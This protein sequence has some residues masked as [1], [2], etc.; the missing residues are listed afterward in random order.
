MPEVRRGSSL[1]LS[2]DRLPSN[3]SPIVS[4][5]PPPPS[6]S[7]APKPDD[8]SPH[9][10]SFFEKR[11]QSASALSQLPAIQ[12]NRAQSLDWGTRPTILETNSD[13]NTSKFGSKTIYANG[14]DN[15]RRSISYA[16]RETASAY[17]DS[18]A[19]THKEW[20]RR[21]K[22]LQEYYDENPQLLPQLPFTWHHG[23]KRWRLFFFVFLAFVDASVVPI[24]L[25]YGMTYGG[26]TPGWIVFAIITSIWGGP[27]Y[28]EAGMRTLRLIK[29]ERFFRPLGTDSRWSFDILTWILALAI[30]VVTVLFIVG[31]A[32]HI[33]FLRVLSMP[34]PA[35]LYCLGGSV[36][37]LTLYHKMGWKAPFRISS[38]A[39]GEK[40]C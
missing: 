10:S 38:T 8:G 5:T 25:Y 6:K 24:A 39:K 30:G 7:K 14:A 32:P 28:F 21:G 22:T 37:L 1:Q 12:Q 36:A 15:E 35:I 13:P 2:R 11:R 20:K 31:G 16:R 9:S 33:V 18:R 3:Q 19:G 40:V 26:H 23:W 29:K 17:Y 34:G 27:A 4:P